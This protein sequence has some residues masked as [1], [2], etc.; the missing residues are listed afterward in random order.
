MWLRMTL[1]LSFLLGA[2]CSNND[3]PNRAALV[4]F[5]DDNCIKRRFTMIN[6]EGV[7]VSTYEADGGLTPVAYFDSLAQA[8]NAY[9][10]ATKASNCPA[11]ITVTPADLKIH[12]PFPDTPSDGGSDVGG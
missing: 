3:L 7:T 12:P 5:V 10:A 6:G 9:P 8:K 1:A 11:N 2:A 4:I